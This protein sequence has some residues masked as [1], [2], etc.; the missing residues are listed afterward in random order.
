MAFMVWAVFFLVAWFAIRLAAACF[1]ELLSFIA[2]SV[3][4]CMLEPV[5]GK[6]AVSWLLGIGF[7]VA[8]SI[9]CNREEE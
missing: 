3:A 2:F 4:V 9:S 7:L 8:L 6:G 5:I 1:V